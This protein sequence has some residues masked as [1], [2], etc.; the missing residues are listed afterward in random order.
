LAKRATSASATWIGSVNK[1]QS[2]VSLQGGVVSDP[3]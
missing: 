3:E 2:T 1:S